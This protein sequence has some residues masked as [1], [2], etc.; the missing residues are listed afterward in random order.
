[1]FKQSRSKA[2]AALAAMALSLLF[3]FMPAQAA[4]LGDFIGEWDTTL[5]AKFQIGDDSE[6]ISTFD[7]RLEL[8]QTG[9]TLGGSLVIAGPDGESTLPI[10]GATL[11]DD[12]RLRLEVNFSNPGGNDTFDSVVEPLFGDLGIDAD[13]GIRFIGWLDALGRCRW[14]GPRPLFAPA[15]PLFVPACPLFVPP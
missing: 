12:G 1:M 6:P 11:Q 2:G 7:G 13:A 5:V 14:V 15:C 3:S 4:E 8:E 10:A 9:V